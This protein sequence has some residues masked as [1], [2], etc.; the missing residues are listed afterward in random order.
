MGPS[1]KQGRTPTRK[2]GSFLALEMESGTRAANAPADAPQPC[3]FGFILKTLKERAADVEH[4]IGEK[5]RI[6]FGA[7][8]D[9]NLQVFS[10]GNARQSIC[11]PLN[12]IDDRRVNN[13]AILLIEARGKMLTERKLDSNL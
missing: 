13:A 11:N 10:S 2:L 12:V 9:S 6:H 7:P 5:V 3:E 1:A 4:A 8:S